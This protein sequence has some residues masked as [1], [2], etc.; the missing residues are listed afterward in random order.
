MHSLI[1]ILKLHLCSLSAGIRCS[2]CGPASPS[3]QWLLWRRQGCLLLLFPSFLGGKNWPSKLI[4]WR[5]LYDGMLHAYY[6]GIDGCLP[7]KS[8]CWSNESCHRISYDDLSGSK[9]VSLTQILE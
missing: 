4:D 6:S 8:Q 3:D 7:T 9:Y 5:S 2:W 1:P